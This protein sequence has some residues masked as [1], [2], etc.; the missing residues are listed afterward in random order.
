[1]V[2]GV[3]MRTTSTTAEARTEICADALAAKPSN[4]NRAAKPASGRLVRSVPST[5][6][7]RA[8]KSRRER[9]GV[10]CTPGGSAAGVGPAGGVK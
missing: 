1:M 4:A 3:S 5:G 7:S 2:G 10:Y 9:A 6:S 8:A